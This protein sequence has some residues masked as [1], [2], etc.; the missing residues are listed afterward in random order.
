[1]LVGALDWARLILREDALQG[2]RGPWS[3]GGAAEP[4]RLSTF[5]AADRSGRPGGRRIAGSLCGGQQIIDLQSR[6]N[7]TNLVWRP[8]KRA[9]LPGLY[10][11]FQHLGL[12]PLELT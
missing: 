1:V 10:T 5:L 3:L 12:A 2:R 7:V 6:L 9:K 4:A 8:T 11:Q